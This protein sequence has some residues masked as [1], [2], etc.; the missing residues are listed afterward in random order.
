MNTR[1]LL[2]LLLSALAP[3][4][5][6]ATSYLITTVA[7]DQ[8]DA[9]PIDGAASQARF[10]I[11]RLVFDA[12][13][14]GYFTDTN[15]HTVR[16]F[17]RDHSVTTLAGQ[18]GVAGF[19][20]GTGSAARF[21]HPEGLGIDASGTLYVADT[22]NQT[23]RRVTADGVVTTLA[24]QKGGRGHADG[25]GTAAQ[26]GS[27][28]AIATTPSGDVLVAEVSDLATNQIR[29]ITPGGQVT[30]LYT[31]QNGVL[32]SNFGITDL[33]VDLSGNIY[34][35]NYGG[36]I[37]KI[38]TDGVATTVAGRLG[39][40]NI[41]DGTGTDARFLSIPCFAFNWVHGEIWV[42]DGTTVRKITSDG[43]V[44]TVLGQ[45]D[46]GGVVD[47]IGGAARVV[48]VPGGIAADPFGDVWVADAYGAVLR[49]IQR[50]AA[51]TPPILTISPLNTAHGYV[52]AGQNV[53]LV[54]SA[55]G[56]PP[57]RYQ[58]LKDATPIAGATNATYTLTA[59]SAADQ[60]AYAVQIS[61]GFGAVDLYTSKATSVAVYTP[62]FAGFSPRHAANGGSFLWAIASGAG[63][64][65]TVG[66]GGK[67]LTSSDGRT[68]TTRAS[69]TSAWLVG[70]TYAAGKFV[71]VGENGTILLSSDGVTWTPAASSGTSQR[72]NNVAYGG[73]HFVAV[74]EGGTIVTSS[75]GQTWT[76]QPSGIT[77]WL[78]GLDYEPAVN[79][80][81]YFYGDS[82]TGRFYASG[83]NGVILE[84]T[85]SGWVPSPRWSSLNITTDIE[86]LAPGPI[87][88]GQDGALASL[89]YSAMYGKGGVS[90][91]GVMYPVGGFVRYASRNSIGLAARFRGLAMGRGAIFAT[92]ENGVIAAGQS[93]DGPWSFIPSGTTANLVGGA[94][95]G[96]SL[97]VVGENETILQSEDLYLSRLT[98]MSTRG[99]V[100]TGGNVMISGF[101]VRGDVPKRILLRAAGPALAK[102]VSGALAT[103]ELTLYDAAN[104]VLASNRGWDGGADA[105]Q[106]A[107]AAASVGAFPFAAG[108][109]DAALLV[110]LPPGSYTAIVSGADAGSGIALV[111][112]Y[113]ADALSAEG[114]R[115]VNISTRGQVRGGDHQLI[116]GFAING[117]AS[118]RVL[119]RAVGPGLAKFGLD[120][121]LAQPKITLYN[122]WNNVLREV[123]PWEQ[124]TSS[125]ET[126]AAGVL[127]GTF[128]LDSGSKDAAAVVTLPPG[129]YTAQV[130]GADGGSGI[131]L[132]EVYD[133]P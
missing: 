41:V 92:G 4:A 64:M 95:V 13:G 94:L 44:M 63:Q 29:K 111:E 48:G 69:G 86:A 67:I 9:G 89:G 120:G 77:T 106:I 50:I 108:S 91:N 36:F 2:A 43:L 7:G 21:D 107:A 35:A 57:I 68:W 128:A 26:F 15:A 105:T 70:V 121:V 112:A 127:A 93:I 65:V 25:V 14:N 126:V 32:G 85:S 71:V 119:I 52:G 20:D 16:R 98:N 24:G 130:S 61:D 10:R 55:V 76:S 81:P 110:T 83:Q 42:E 17:N 72:L 66:T 39:G 22:Y 8:L 101:V 49:R 58:W 113:D 60:G 122:H 30:T 12:S 74:G 132:I 40:G 28:V 23:I 54:S 124:Q 99:E 82:G 133:L 131:A 11:G 103:P 37:V 38:T 97:Y 47:G 129:T 62:A 53:E 33:A 104:R 27:V 109:A 59:A 87:G 73:D 80:G 90:V 3:V 34:V 31:N 96:N 125:D 56:T 84:E 116:A 75:D 45:V 18:N 123:G 102:W 118:R 1:L 6:R 115:A 5:T 51:V 117:S 114:S 19:A 88:V 100:G 78:R 46:D 79:Y